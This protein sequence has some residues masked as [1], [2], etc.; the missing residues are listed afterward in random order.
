MVLISAPLASGLGGK[1][2]QLVHGAKLPPSVVHSAVL[3]ACGA[4][5]CCLCLRGSTR[6]CTLQACLRKRQCKYSNNTA[7]HQNGCSSCLSLDAVVERRETLRNRRNILKIT[8]Q[9][10]P[11]RPCAPSLA[12]VHLWRRCCSSLHAGIAPCW[13]W[14]PASGFVAK[15]IMESQ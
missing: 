10:S 1:R 3:C 13:W 15:K 11:V 6:W 9:T 4:R 12:H 8:L 7:S 2:A 14:D 5:W